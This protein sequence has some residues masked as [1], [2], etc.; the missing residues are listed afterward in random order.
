MKIAI[1]GTG[2]Y[3]MALANIFND[4]KC[5]VMMWTNSKEEMNSLVKE[6]KSNR[7]DYNIPSSINISTDM[8]DVTLDASI[9]VM[10][11]PAKFIGSVS[12]QLKEYYSSKQVICIASKGIEQDTCLFLYD[13]VRNNIG[14]MLLWKSHLCRTHIPL[15]VWYVR[16]TLF[17]YSCSFLNMHL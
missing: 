6:R 10:A 16:F 1:L 8:K 7:I 12:K 5:N 13:V 17:T 9:I 15:V 14:R 4:N 11:V 2:A 3:G